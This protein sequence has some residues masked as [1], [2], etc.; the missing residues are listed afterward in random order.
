[1][2]RI[3]IYFILL[4]AASLNFSCANLKSSLSKSGSSDSRDYSSRPTYAGTSRDSV[5]VV[6][7]PTSYN[8]E[9]P[10]E[11]S[12]NRNT[13][14][15]KIADNTV[16]KTGADQNQ[17]LEVQYAE[18][19]KLA[20][21]VLYELEVNERQKEGLLDRFRSASSGDRETISQELNKLDANQITL[22]KAYVRIYKDGKSNWT[23][24]QRSVEDTLLGLRGVG[25]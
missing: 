22:Y 12:E 19:D 17:N 21:R 5:A 14:D 7:T 20:D 18:M 4:L 3:S 8:V 11:R 16:R 10:D 6:K 9:R 23:A 24:V 13:P 2:H 25:K 15:R 1:M